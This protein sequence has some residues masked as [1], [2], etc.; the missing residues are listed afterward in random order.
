MTSQ[1]RLKRLAQVLKACN[2]S[3]TDPLKIVSDNLD[4][5][6]LDELNVIYERQAEGIFIDFYK[7]GYKIYKN[8]QDA[9]T[10]FDDLNSRV[11]IIEDELI[12]IENVSLPTFF[13]NLIFSKK[14]QNLM[15]E[16][17][18]IS[19]HD[20]AN[21]K[22]IFL[23]EHI[24][25]VE[26][27]YKNRLIEFFNSEYSLLH[28]YETL[29]NKFNESEYLSFF[30]DNFIN[31]A[32]DIE[33]IDDRFYKTLIKIQNIVDN[34]NREFELYKNKFS[35]EQFNSDLKKEKEKYIKN[36]QENLS[37]FLSKVNAL[38][39]QFGVYILLVFRFEDEIIPLIAT[40]ILIISWSAFSF[41][42][43]NIMKKTIDFLEKKFNAVFEKIS[44]ESGINKEILADDKN[45]ILDKIS[46]IKSMIHWY[47]CVVVI[48][49]L[50][51]IVFSG[52]NI[53]KEFNKQH[54]QEKTTKTKNE[55]SEVPKIQENNQV[56]K[57]ETKSIE[58][59]M[60]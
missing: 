4:T 19:Y 41:F 20:G 6:T 39:V 7:Q 31:I 57:S 26:V 54:V 56:I 25:K 37:E 15:I 53:Y 38:P 60:K 52:S 22:F 21:K 3:S 13:E 33:H 44:N 5:N 48:F 28:V 59:K 32:K 27:G 23:S 29:T 16:K 34:S 24:G 43:L 42:S 58:V 49:S 14:I 17:E 11:L 46:N 9:I 1:N 51:F 10:Y 8:K 55:K 18:V 36:I 12:Y 50:I 30:R 47:K 35:F 2:D 40:V 45:E